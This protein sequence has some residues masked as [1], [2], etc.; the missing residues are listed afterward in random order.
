M[1]VAGLRSRILYTSRRL[2]RLRIRLTLTRVLMRCRPGMPGVILRVICRLLLILRTRRPRF[3]GRLCVYPR[4][5]RIL[6]R[7][8]WP[9]LL[10][11]RCSCLP[12]ILR[13]GL[14]RTLL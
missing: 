8:R 12:G 4:T 6:P 9:A 13:F 7:A 11:I 14:L 2:S 3:T 10:S 5:A 1:L